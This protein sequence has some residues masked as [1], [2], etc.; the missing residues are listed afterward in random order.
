MYSGGWVKPE[1]VF[2]CAELWRKLSSPALQSFPHRSSW[3]RSVRPRMAPVEDCH[4]GQWKAPFCL[5]SIVTLW[6]NDFYC[7]FGQMRNYYPTFRELY[8]YWGSILS[9]EMSVF[10]NSFEFAAV[11]VKIALVPGA[12][13][14]KPIILFLYLSTKCLIWYVFGLYG[15]EE[16]P[17]SW[18]LL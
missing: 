9:P 2:A 17:W 7:N 11:C 12:Y 14:G 10:K 3:I 13:A 4:A 5:S 8:F 18:Q 1:L 15:C 16:T 6:L